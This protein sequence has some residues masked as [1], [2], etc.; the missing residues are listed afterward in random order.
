MQGTRRR[1][2]GAGVLAIA[3]AATL[4]G[5]AQGGHDMGD[6]VT[7]KLNGSA[8][9]GQLAIRATKVERVTSD[10]M[11]QFGLSSKGDDAYLAHFTVQRVSG[12]FDTDAVGDLTNDAWGLRADD[13]LQAGPSLD[14][15]DR[16]DVLQ[17][18]CP[19]ERKAIAEALTGNG[20]ADV[21]AVLLAPSGSTVDA[22]SYMRAAPV[23][24]APEGDSTITWR[25][26]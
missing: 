12:T 26:S 22:V 11:D 23:D 21:C 3:A 18:A 16:N 1:Q 6:R 5:C 24:E 14:A 10:A 8:F 17:D 19:F 20:T 15:S 4:T 13:R 9:H 25:S 7:T 2:I